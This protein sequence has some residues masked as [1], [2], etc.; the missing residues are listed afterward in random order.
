MTNR[1]VPLSLALVAALAASQASFAASPAKP[2]DAAQTLPAA[3]AAALDA[4]LK[5]EWRKDTRKPRQ[6]GSRRI[7]RDASVTQA[8][9][10]SGSS[11]NQWSPWCWQR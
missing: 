8:G 4:A 2:A 1:I 5:G 3:D 6:A 11:L 10:K 9:E 7:E